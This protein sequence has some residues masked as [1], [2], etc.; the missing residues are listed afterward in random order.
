MQAERPADKAS[1]AASFARQADISTKLGSRFNAVL[2]RTILEDLDQDG[3]SWGVLG[4]W[5]GRPV[6]EILAL[7]LLGGLH[8]LVLAGRA[9]ALAAFYP[10]A[11]GT[12]PLVEM[13]P[14]LRD[15]LAGETHFL[16]RMLEHAPQ[17]NEVQRSAVV[18]GGLAHVFQA[19]RRPLALREIGASGGLNLL[20]DRYHY[21]LGGQSWGPADSALHLGARWHGRAPV[22]P[23]TIPVASRRGCDLNPLALDTIEGRLRLKSYVWPDQSERLARLDAALRIAAA[24]PPSVVRAAAGD[25]LAGEL[26]DPVPGSATV[27]LHTYVWPYIPEVERA[28]ISALIE[29]AGAKATADRPLAWLRFEEAHQDR[30]AILLDLW[31]GPRGLVLGTGHPHGLWVDWDWRPAA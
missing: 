17:T 30:M 10:S 11:G 6:E 24:E 19:L 1:I 31:P 29:A 9:P 12:R 14:V 5:R 21:A 28:R 18:L 2:C 15:T 7:R 3:P 23:A 22:L 4:Q 27:V 16:R 26:A 20:F 13:A 8:F 25:W